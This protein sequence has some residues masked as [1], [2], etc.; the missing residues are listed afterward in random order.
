[1]RV[2]TIVST[3]I[4]AVAGAVP[5]TGNAQTPSTASIAGLVVDSSGVPLELVEVSAS[6]VGRGAHTDADGRFSISSLR[7][8]GNRF[9]IRRLGWRA[10]DTTIVLGANSTATVRI[11]MTRVPQDLLAVHIVSQD[12]CPIRTLEGFECRRRAGVGAFRDSAEIAALKPECTADIV[13]GMEGLRRVSGFMCPRYIP[14]TGWRCLRILVDGREVSSTN[15]I[16][17]LKKD[18]IGVE[19]YA[20]YETEPEWYKGEAFSPARDGVAT[21]QLM[22]GTRMVYRQ[23]SVGGRNCSLLIY[24]THFAVRFDPGLDQ[25]HLTTQVMKARRDSI[26]GSQSDTSKSKAD[27]SPPKK[28]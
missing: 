2:R 7:A 25:S 13:E 24:W 23:P 15:P 22:P 12:E 9:L 8:G 5:Y 6:A 4:V 18:F 10:V 21:K 16:P 3:V 20:D 26:L 1:M 14:V 17:A 28:P 27:S 19:F 11:V